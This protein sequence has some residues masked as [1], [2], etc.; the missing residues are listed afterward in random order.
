MYLKNNLGKITMPNNEKINKISRYL[1]EV[2]H[3][4]KAFYD[5]LAEEEK[6]V[7]W[8]D[9]GDNDEWIIEDVAKYLKLND[10]TFEIE[11]TDNYYGYDLFILYQGKK[12]KIVFEGDGI[13][14]DITLRT[15]NEVIMPDYEIRFGVDSLGGD[16]LAFIPLTQEEVKLLA[17]K[18]GETF[19]QKLQKITT[20]SQMFD[21]DF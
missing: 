17:E 9:W 14:R 12:V 19:E 11:K 20:D 1:T 7:H 2:S 13:L 10:L 16:T 6:I 5:V 21:L 4:P 3:N 18:F 8:I 15:L